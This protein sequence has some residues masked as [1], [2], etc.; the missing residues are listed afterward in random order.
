MNTITV[1][2]VEYYWEEVLIEGK[3]TKILVPKLESKK[4]KLIKILYNLNIGVHGNKVICGG[5]WPVM[6]ANFDGK[7]IYLVM[8]SNHENLHVYCYKFDTKNAIF[9][10]AEEC[11]NWLLKMNYLPEEL[12]E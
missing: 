4:D 8:S 5:K 7:R 3:M 9:S 12:K 6:V 10:S 11:A 1:A 2:N